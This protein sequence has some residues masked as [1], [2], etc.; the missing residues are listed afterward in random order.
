M[1]R[2]LYEDCYGPNLKE[3]YLA[4]KLSEDGRSLPM[5]MAGGDA[6]GGYQALWVLMKDGRHSR[7][8]NNCSDCDYSGSINFLETQ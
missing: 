8:V 2:K 3:S 4:I 7:F 5:F 1:P 6:A